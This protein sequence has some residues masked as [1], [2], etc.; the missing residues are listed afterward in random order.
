MLTLS[1]VYEFIQKQLLNR[2]PRRLAGHTILCGMGRNGRLIYELIRETDKNH[3]IVI[4]EKGDS[5]PYAQQLAKD[6]ATWWVQNDF[7][8]KAVLQSARVDKAA[9]IIF[10]THQD[11][12]NLNAVV[13]LQSHGIRPGRAAFLPSR[14]SGNARQFSA[15]VIP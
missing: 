10:S 1:V 4:I 14:R 6:P 5:N 2:V 12:D 3:K 13:E 8:R 11:L 15:D 9:R 7:T